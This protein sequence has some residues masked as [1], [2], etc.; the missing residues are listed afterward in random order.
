[1]NLL[2]IK[3]IVDKI[4]VVDDFL[5]EANKHNAVLGSNGYKVPVPDHLLKKWYADLLKH[6]DTLEEKLTNVTKE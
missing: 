3:E 5:R 2:V 1:M 6:R 4:V